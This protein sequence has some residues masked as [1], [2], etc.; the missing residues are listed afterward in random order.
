MTGELLTGL[1]TAGA[2][3]AFLSTSSGLAIAVA[4]VLSQ[5]VTGRWPGRRRLGGVAAFRVGAVLAVTVPCVL[6]LSSPSVGVARTVGLAFAVAAST[7]C[8]L[9]LL[10][11]LVARAHRPRRRRRAARRRAR[12]GG[13]GR[14]DADQPTPPPG[15]SPCCWDSP[16]RGASRPPS[17]R[18][19]S[20]ACSPATACPPT[21][22]ASWSGCTRRSR[23]PST[24][25]DAEQA[26][27]LH[28]L[29]SVLPARRR[30]SP[31]G[32]VFLPARRRVRECFC[33]LGNRSSRRH[34]RSPQGRSRWARIL[35]DPCRP[36]GTDS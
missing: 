33:L 26:G 15:G 19:S 17:S 12:L 21:P 6:A 2:F 10:G 3:A 28:R 14:L 16:P 22:G 7:F 29:G 13:R 25:A 32:G 31:S 36:D 9:L 18:W 4:G 1:V 35:H 34:D 11:H 20:S 24:A 5:D 23:W 27:T 8:P 30:S